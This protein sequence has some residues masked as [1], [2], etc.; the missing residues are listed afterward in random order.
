MISSGVLLFVS[1]V[2]GSSFCVSL[3]PDFCFHLSLSVPKG[4]KDTTCFSVQLSSQCKSLVSL[5]GIFFS[6][7]FSYLTLKFVFGFFCVFSS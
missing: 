3:F 7:E 1:S 6:P 4:I 2:F 5:E